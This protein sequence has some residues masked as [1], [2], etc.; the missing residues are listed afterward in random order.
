[1]SLA[2][3]GH[4]PKQ[5]NVFE[6][7]EINKFLNEASDVDYLGIKVRKVVACLSYEMLKYVYVLVDNRGF[8]YLWRYTLM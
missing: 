1:M 5:S 6:G 2:S 3:V 8:W 7:D 4:V